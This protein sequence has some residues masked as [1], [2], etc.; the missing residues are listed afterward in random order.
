MAL[1][2]S[3]VDPTIQAAY[4]AEAFEDTFGAVV[5]VELSPV[6]KNQYNIS[7]K[8]AIIRILEPSRDLTR[9]MEQIRL[10]GRSAFYHRACESW[11]VKFNETKYVPMKARIV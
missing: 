11:T 1:N 7:Y 8:T 2:I 3:F 5:S 10:N 4:M 6:K 9:F